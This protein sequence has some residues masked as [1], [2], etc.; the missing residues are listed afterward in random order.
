MRSPVSI[1]RSRAACWCA[2][3]GLALAGCGSLDTRSTPALTSRPP[4]VVAL[5]PFDARPDDPEAEVRLELFRLIFHSYLSDRGFHALTPE[6]VDARLRRARLDTPEQVRTTGAARLGE[7]LGADALLIGDR[8]GVSSFQALLAYRRGLSGRFKL[9]STRDGQELWHAE[10]TEYDTGGVLVDSGQVIQAVSDTVQAGRDTAY[11]RLCQLFCRQVTATLPK[12]VHRDESAEPAPEIASVSVGQGRSGTLRSGDKIEVEVVGTPAAMGAF[13]LRPL[14][15]GLALVEGAPGRYRG[16]HTVLPGE[17]A[18]SVTV[19]A[20]LTNSFGRVVRKDA[21]G[22]LAIDAAPPAMPPAVRVARVG[23]GV[24]VSW[25]A[26]GG[27]APAA[28][29][30]FRSP[31]PGRGFEPVGRTPERRWVDGQ[32]TPQARYQVIAVDGQGNQSFPAGPAALAA[33][34]RS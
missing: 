4:Q 22:T 11:V 12:V 33:E 34:V 8:I 25:D 18:E 16:V 2:S 7:V 5:L 15:S 9:V 10:A 30:V 23:G 24:E 21:P 20:R 3:A 29:Q 27:E 13:D 28:Y 26:P 17:A 31:G 1:A 14:R 32:A 6:Y 19:T